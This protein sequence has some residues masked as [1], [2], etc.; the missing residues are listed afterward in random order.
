MIAGALGGTSL[1]GSAIPNAPT[2]ECVLLDTAIDTEPAT[3]VEPDPAATSMR[4]YLVCGFQTVNSSGNP[5]GTD[6][7]FI[8]DVDVEQAEVIVGAASD[9]LAADGDVFVSDEP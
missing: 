2:G 6:D 3:Y 9:L 1:L 7:V 5:V 4:L 8:L